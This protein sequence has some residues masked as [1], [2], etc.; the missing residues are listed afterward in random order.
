MKGVYE[1]IG[2]LIKDRRKDKGITQ[3][4]LGKIVDTKQSNIALYESGARPISIRKL[5]SICKALGKKL[6]ITFE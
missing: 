1:R 6:K 2:Q 5:E 3:A 4:Q